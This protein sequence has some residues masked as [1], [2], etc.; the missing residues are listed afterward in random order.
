MYTHYRHTHII[1]AIIAITIIITITII[2]GTLTSFRTKLQ[3][4]PMKADKIFGFAQNI[5]AGLS[6]LHSVNTH[7]RTHAHTHTH[8]YTQHEI[9]H[10]D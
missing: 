3:G 7:T 10:R 2:T 5:A 9:I 8:T 6:Y 1:T 4:K